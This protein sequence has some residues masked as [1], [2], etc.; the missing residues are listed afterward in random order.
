MNDS[1]VR[2]VVV[3]GLNDSSRNA[4]PRFR[5]VALSDVLKFAY[6]GSIERPSRSDSIAGQL[7]D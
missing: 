3:Q 4:L 5:E 2:F 7:K 1:R 6:K